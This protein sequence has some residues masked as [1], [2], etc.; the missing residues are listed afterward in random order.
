MIKI[1]KKREKGLK[2]NLIIK[3]KMKSERK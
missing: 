3:K 2:C 1:G